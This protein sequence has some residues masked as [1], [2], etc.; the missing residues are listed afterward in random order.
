ME[1]YIRFKA[2]E[3]FTDKTI[4][5]VEDLQREVDRCGTLYNYSWDDMFNV[6][7]MTTA[8]WDGYLYTD[9]MDECLK[10]NLPLSIVRM[11]ESVIGHIV[12]HIRVN[13]IT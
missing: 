4:V 8:I 10:L 2:R 3:V 11:V 9:Y 7:S 6:Q 5:L 1:R 13:T 12:N